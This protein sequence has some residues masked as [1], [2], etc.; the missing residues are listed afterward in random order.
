MTQRSGFTIGE[1]A[2]ATGTQA[3]TVRYYERIGLLPAPGRSSGNY[4]VYGA[5]D[6]ERAAFVKRGRD[7]GFAIDE[8]RTL[9][10]LADQKERECGEIDA[11]AREHLADVERKIADLERLAR[12]LRHL[13]GQCGGGRISDCRI[14]E[15]L[16]SAG[17][18]TLRRRSAR[19]ILTE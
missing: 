2:K 10:A 12:E 11:I 18:P 8:I 7:L 5:K 13:I 19:T 14:V 6:I 16:A 15:A 1:L 9:L 4:R 17:R 3:E